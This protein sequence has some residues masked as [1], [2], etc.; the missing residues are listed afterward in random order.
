MYNRHW[1]HEVHISG[2]LNN[3][4]LHILANQILDSSELIVE[5]CSYWISQFTS[6]MIALISKEPHT[7]SLHHL[8]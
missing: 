5:S 3:L 4:L 8:T 2:Q 1:A 6:P 7:K